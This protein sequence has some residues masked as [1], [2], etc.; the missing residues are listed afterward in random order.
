MRITLFSRV[1]DKIQILK[2][3]DLESEAFL[4][5]TDIKKTRAGN[6]V[7]ATMVVCWTFVEFILFI[8][9][10]TVNCFALV[11]NIPKVP[12]ELNSHL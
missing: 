9:P 1:K 8:H 3:R 7:V 4:F 11:L 10:T 2:P 6:P 5:E 12:S